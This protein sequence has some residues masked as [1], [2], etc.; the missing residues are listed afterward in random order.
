MVGLASVYADFLSMR[1]G[2]RC[3]LE[4]LVVT[5]AYR[6]R[7]IGRLLLDAA[8]AWAR[9]RGCTHLELDSGLGRRD[10]HRFYLAQG[11]A[12]ESLLFRR[13]IG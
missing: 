8:A 6:S 11:L 5:S 12:H 9:E 4:D 10:S 7:G 13:R 1:F 3:W 2:W